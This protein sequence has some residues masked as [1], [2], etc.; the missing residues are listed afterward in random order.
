LAGGAVTGAGEGEGELV[1]IAPVQNLHGT[2]M[3]RQNPTP[4]ALYMKSLGSTTR[5]AADAE[6]VVLC[7]F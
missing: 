7:R 1:A 4:A 3:P 5:L 6:V 2:T